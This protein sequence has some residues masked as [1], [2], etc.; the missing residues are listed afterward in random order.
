MRIG[1]NVPNELLKRVKAIQ[2][3]VNVSQICRNAL[4]EF[5]QRSDR[6]VAQAADDD[7]KK[8]LEK[9]GQSDLFPLVEP[10]WEGM[11]LEDARDWLTRAT[12][13]NWDRYLEI[14]HF[15]ERQG[16]EN[17]TWFADVHGI[18]E[19]KR[20][21]HREQEHREWLL[22]QYEIN[23]ELQAIT[24]ARERYQRAF[25]DYLE[26]V[27]KLWEKQQKGKREKE[28]AERRARWETLRQPEV[29]PQLQR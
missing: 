19:V 29:P 5:A 6:V 4:E 24:E 22:A 1:I 14:R 7:I 15:L 17:E 12:A 25:V 28:M 2:P 13:E 16:R 27:R 23:P 8:H 20:F 18:D 11:A 10:D 26:E 9:I 3:E 21:P